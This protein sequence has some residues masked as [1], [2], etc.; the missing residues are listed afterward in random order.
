VGAT[1]DLAALNIELGSDYSGGRADLDSGAAPV[2]REDQRGKVRNG[3]GGGGGRFVFG[4][5]WAQFTVI[6]L[7]VIKQ[8][9]ATL[10]NNV[11][12]GIKYPHLHIP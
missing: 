5:H 10:G 4:F 12:D 3:A 2:C 9:I 11:I 1:H 8:I 7:G 6:T